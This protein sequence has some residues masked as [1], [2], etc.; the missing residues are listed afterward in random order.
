MLNVTIDINGAPILQIH[1]LNIGT[2]Q[3]VEKGPGDLRRYA[4]EIVD[5]QH[6]RR[7][8]GYADHCRN[9]GAWKLVR[10]I[11]EAFDAS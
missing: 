4:I 2:P 10:K 7:Q 1:A 5:I 3:D 6:G 8:R 11:L 9:D